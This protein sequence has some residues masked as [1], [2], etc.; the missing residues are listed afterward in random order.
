[1]SH[2][3]GGRAANNETLPPM[4]ISRMGAAS[5]AP[6]PLSDFRETS[7]P[8]VVF[9]LRRESWGFDSHVG[10]SVDNLG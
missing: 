5:A 9:L 6:V 4:H 2:I 1:M 7:N 10:E 3:A 8:G